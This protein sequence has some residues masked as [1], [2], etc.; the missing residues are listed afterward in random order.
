MT[1]YYIDPTSGSDT[2][3]GLSWAQAWKTMRGLRV[4][5]IV[6]GAGDEIRFAKSSVYTPSM[7]AYDRSSGVV[8]PLW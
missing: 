2:N 6:P 1:I 3:T 4:A 7:G 8:Y 5:S